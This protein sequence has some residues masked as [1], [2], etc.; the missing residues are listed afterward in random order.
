MSILDIASA[1]IE[2]LISNIEDSIPSQK[3]IHITGS[4]DSA[5]LAAVPFSNLPKVYQITIIILFSIDV[6]LCCWYA[7]HEVVDPAHCIGDGRVDGG[8]FCA[9]TDAPCH[10]P[11]L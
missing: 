5:V 9:T 3:T 7:A 6:G 8:N 4:E 10:S 1:I 2:D 11:D